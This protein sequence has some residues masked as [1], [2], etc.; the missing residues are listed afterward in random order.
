MSTAVLQVKICIGHCQRKL[1][2]S[3]PHTQIPS[4]NLLHRRQEDGIE[5]MM[6][7]TRQP[8]SRTANYYISASSVLET[9]KDT[10]SDWSYLQDCIYMIPGA[11][12][13]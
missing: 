13:R 6:S 1:P 10:V 9:T 4:G 3:F 8:L 2:P 7:A 12:V 11:P 5:F